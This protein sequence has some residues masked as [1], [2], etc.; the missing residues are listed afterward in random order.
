[1]PDGKTLD[2]HYKTLTDRALLK[3]SAEGGFTAGAEQVFDKELARRSLTSDEAKRYFAPEWLDKADVG[4]VGVLVLEGGERI[5]AE[6]T[7]LNEEGDRL[8][9]KVIPPD[10]P[11]RNGRRTHRAIPLRRIVPFEPQPHLMEQW[12]FSDPCR[13]RTFSAPRFI[14]MTTIFLGWV[15]GSLPLF[16]FLPL[17]RRPYGLQEASIVYPSDQ[18]HLLTVSRL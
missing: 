9:V 10:S 6:V 5:T 16:L 1:M 15:V 12:P 11:P 8:S 17:T 2:E 18:P 13:D 4:T 7:G 3:L 14:L